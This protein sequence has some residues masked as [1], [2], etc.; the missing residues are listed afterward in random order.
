MALYETVF[1]TRPDLTTSQNEALT[2]ELG[3]LIKK[4]DGKIARTEI[5]GLRDLAYRIN[6]ARKGFYTMLHIDGPA[7][8]KDELERILRQNEDVLRYMTVALKDLPKDDSI[9][10]KNK[11]AAA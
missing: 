7:D 4:K 3:A 10:M 6:K 5:W 2:K 1:I 9:I 8:A 11:G